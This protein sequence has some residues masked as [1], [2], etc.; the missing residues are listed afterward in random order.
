MAMGVLTKADGL[1]LEFLVVPYAHYRQAWE[2][3]QQSGSVVPA[4]RGGVKVSPWVTAMNKVETPF[5]EILKKTGVQGWLA[6]EVAGRLNADAE[7][8]F[9]EAHGKGLPWSNVHIFDSRVRR[10]I[11]LAE[12]PSFG[13]S[14]FDYAPNSNG[15]ADY[16]ALTEEVVEH[17][18]I[19]KPMAA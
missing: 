2:E 3:V 15:A 7:S 1:A 14:I 4:T 18:R 11:R 13:Q 9:V 6:D 8:F 19:E 16:L 17:Y 10:N 5:T 12:A